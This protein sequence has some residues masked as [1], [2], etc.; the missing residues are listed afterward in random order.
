MK[1]TIL[2][3]SLLLMCLSLN[4]LSL[5]FTPSGIDVNQISTFSFD[6]YNSATQPILT[7][8]ILTND[9]VEQ[10][11][12]MQVVI[13]WNGIQILEE[14]KARF[15]T[16]QAL[17]PNQVLNLT[18]RDLIS[19]DASNYFVE[20]ELDFNISDMVDKYP[21]LKDAVLSGYFPDGTLQLKVSLRP[22]GST[23]WQE[24]S[25]FTIRIRNAG[26]IYLTGPGALIGRQVPVIGHLPV[27]FFWNAVNTGFNDQRL[28]IR[29]FPPNNP[30]RL[31]TVKSTG[32][33]VYHSSGPEESGFSQYLP[34]NNGYYYAWMVYSDL[35]NQDNIHLGRNTG[36]SP[37]LE[38][39]WFVFRYM[40]EE[41][42]EA[43]PEDVQILLKMLGN[44]MLTN[45]FSQGYTPTG[46]VIFNGKSYWGQDAVNILGNLVGKELHVDITE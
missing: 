39:N 1:T 22:D 46:E 27:S 30:P 16:A 34:L 37:K 38:S 21:T 15:R 42:G 28:V 25:I 14:G 17:A 5:V 3:I 12:Q 7:N 45:I 19:S 24:P 26:G 29:E 4:A 9:N 2:F 31:S 23:T 43:S 13:T 36:N 8:A 35:Y 33:E 32:V 40:M 20:E 18:N 6:P 41:G 10:F 11:V 44:S